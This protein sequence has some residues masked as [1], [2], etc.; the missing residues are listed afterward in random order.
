M[1]QYDFEESVGCWVTMTAHELRRALDTELSKENITFRQWE[2]LAWIALQGE[3]SQV[4]LAERIGIEAPTLAGILA[5]MERDGWLERFTCPSDGRR[6]RI[7]ATPKAEAVWN[8]TVDCCHRVRERATRG[9]SQQELESL[10]QTCER[11]RKNLSGSEENP[12]TTAEVPT[13]ASVPH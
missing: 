4:E 12:C 10:R 8:R 9:I 2:V 7:R 5:R 6:K 1:L 3:P 13:A 11:I